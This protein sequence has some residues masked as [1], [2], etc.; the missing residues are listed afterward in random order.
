[1]AGMMEVRSLAVRAMQQQPEVKPRKR[2]RAE[3]SRHADDAS[4]QQCYEVLREQGCRQRDITAA[5]YRLRALMGNVSAKNACRACIHSSEVC[6]S[7]YNL[8]Q[9]G[10]SE[11]LISSVDCV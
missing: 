1:M 9:D 3:N 8:N 6:V 5:F 7:P 4:A 11:M 2:D 10:G